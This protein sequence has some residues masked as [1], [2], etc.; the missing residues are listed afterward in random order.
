MLRYIIFA[1]LIVLLI[2]NYTAEKFLSF[3]LKREIEEK[4]VI[5]FKCILYVIT[6]TG[7]V[8]IMLL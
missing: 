2:L 1:I 4:Q 5:I 6:L 3:V 8:A 7:V